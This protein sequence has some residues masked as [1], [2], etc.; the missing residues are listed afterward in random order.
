MNICA[1]LEKIGRYLHLID[2]SKHSKHDEIEIDKVN[3][4]NLSQDYIYARNILKSVHQGYYQE[5]HDIVVIS[6]I[7]ERTLK[8]AIPLHI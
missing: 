4:C 6:K 2:S 3:H 1:I 5:Q 7:Y 8:D